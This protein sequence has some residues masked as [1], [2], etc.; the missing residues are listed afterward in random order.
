MDGGSLC[1]AHDDTLGED[2]AFA[3]LKPLP[4]GPAVDDDLLNNET[5]VNDA[6]DVIF[7]DDAAAS[8]VVVDDAD[9]DE[10]CCPGAEVEGG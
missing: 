7:D 3:Q 5:V 9:D 4:P 6:V 8:V 1:V 10:P 2:G